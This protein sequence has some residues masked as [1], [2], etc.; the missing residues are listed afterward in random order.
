M[1]A[2][3]RRLGRA[4]APPLEGAALLLYRYPAPASEVQTSG[5]GWGSLPGPRRP[6]G[7]PTTCRHRGFPLAA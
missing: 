5:K 1:R 7:L 6:A 2:G 4:D 3:G